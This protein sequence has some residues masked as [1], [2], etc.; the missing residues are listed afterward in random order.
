M[1]VYVKS[2]Q[3]KGSLERLDS[4]LYVYGEVGAEKAGLGTLTFSATFQELPAQTD[5][6]H[7]KTASGKWFTAFLKCNDGV[8]LQRQREVVSTLKIPFFPPLK[9]SIVVGKSVKEHLKT[10]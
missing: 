10:Y 1:Y 5:I 2:C 7:C 8:R 4:I 3:A 9:F 6:R